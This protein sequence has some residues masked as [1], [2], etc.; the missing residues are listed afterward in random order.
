MHFHYPIRYSFDICIF[1][2][3]N[4]YNSFLLYIK[5]N[6]LHHKKSDEI[7]PRFFLFRFS[8]CSGDRFFGNFSSS[9][10]PGW[11]T[12]RQVER[13]PV[14]GPR[15]LPRQQ[16]GPPAVPNQHT[17][18]FMCALMKCVRNWSKHIVVTGWVWVGLSE[19]EYYHNYSG[20][21]H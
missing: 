17:R 19:W 3:L 16:E 7:R 13:P 18:H 11:E 1:S 20:W 4:Q 8:K 15:W 2:V 10:Q 5:I 6:N 9:W 21:C 14:K 12:F